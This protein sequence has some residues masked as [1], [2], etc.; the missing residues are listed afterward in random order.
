VQP[1]TARS[2]EDDD[3]CRSRGGRGFEYAAQRLAVVGAGAA[4]QEPLVLRGDEHAHAVDRR[5][6]NDDAIVVVRSNPPAREMRRRPGLVERVTRRLHAARIGHGLDATQRGLRAQR[7][8]S[9]PD[10]GNA[11][12]SES[13]VGGIPR[14]G[15]RG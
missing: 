9:G 1:H 5:S 7:Y 2:R 10:L 11:M 3:R 15:K 6:R 14:A 13:V 12:S 4:A 8:R